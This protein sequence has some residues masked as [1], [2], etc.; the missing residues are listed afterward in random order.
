MN[1]QITYRP[2]GLSALIAVAITGL[3]LTSFDSLARPAAAPTTAQVPLKLEPIVVTA[4]R[5]TAT[6]NL[7]TL[8]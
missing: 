5:L 2:R 3:T 1:H 6:R 4:K 7:P 8:R